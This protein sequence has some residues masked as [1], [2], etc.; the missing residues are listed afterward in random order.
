MNKEL[1]L[2]LYGC[3]F[4][5]TNPVKQF[6]STSILQKKIVCTTL[7]PVTIETNDILMVQHFMHTNLPEQRTNILI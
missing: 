2:L 6:A 3:L 7:L 4:L 1:L 5:H